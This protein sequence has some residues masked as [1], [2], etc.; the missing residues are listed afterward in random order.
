LVV[1][2]YATRFSRRRIDSSL[3]FSG[4]VI[5]YLADIALTVDGGGVLT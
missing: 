2:N 3:N 5:K 4:T 1:R